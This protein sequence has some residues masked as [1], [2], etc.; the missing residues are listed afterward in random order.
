M[1]LSQ[2]MGFRGTVTYR[3][4]DTQKL[5]QNEFNKALLNGIEQ[6]L[7]IRKFVRKER[8]GHSWSFEAKVSQF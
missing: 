5:S 2:M 3:I 4:Q 6:C 1:L 7:R 8:L